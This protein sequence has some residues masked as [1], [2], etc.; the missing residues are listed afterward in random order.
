MYIL[1]PGQTTGQGVHIR[2]FLLLQYAKLSQMSWS[3]NN[4]KISINFIY[5]KVSPPEEKCTLQRK[6]IKILSAKT[7][8]KSPE[9]YN[10]NTHCTPLLF[11][12]LHLATGEWIYQEYVTLLSSILC[13]IG[14]CQQEK[15]H[16]G[17]AL[18]PYRLSK[19]LRMELRG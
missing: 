2:D 4:E 8:L 6:Q 18:Q 19:Y 9:N 7:G 14:A 13:I 17:D 11:L 15:S 5:V 1:F 10:V 16:V 12:P 3:Y